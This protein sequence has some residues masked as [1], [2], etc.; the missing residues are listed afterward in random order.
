MSFRTEGVTAGDRVGIF[1][2]RSWPL[3]AGILGIHRA[4]AAY[5]PLDP[6][7]PE[8]RNRGVLE[9][10]DVAA[11]LT[12]SDL[13]GRLPAG[14]WVAIDVE[15]VDGVG[16]EPG[17]DPDLAPESPAYILYTSGSTGRPKGVVVNHANLR[18][19][20]EARLLVYET[21]PRRFLLVPSVAFDSSVAGIFWTLA[22]GGTLVIPTDEQVRDP[23]RLA[24]LVAH[25]GVTGLLCVPSL[26]AQMMGVGAKDLQSLETAI[27]AGESCPSRLV[28]EHFRVLPH[29]R[30]FNEYGPTEATVWA[31][32]HEV[33]ADDAARPVAIGRP[34]PG[35]RVDVVDARGRPVPA[36]IPGHAWIQGPTVAE[37]YWRRADLTADRF[38][39]GAGTGEHRYRTGDR[40]ARAADGR[41]MF[42]GRED[43]QI[44]LR[45]Y[46]IEPGEV[47]ASILELPGVEEAAVVARSPGTG[48]AT[49][50]DHGARQLVAFLRTSHAG[51]PGGLAARS[52][53]AA[54]GPHDTEPPGG[55]LRAAASAERQ[56]RSAA[57]P[58]H[59][60]RSRG[61]SQAGRAGAEPPGNRR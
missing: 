37:G 60:A 13:R 58:G 14:R 47:E 2:G 7:Y 41:L 55:A 23:R 27:V 38:Q 52:R 4:G 61:R 3:V 8:A 12:T 40:M 11:V 35:V 21:P 59:G 46:R 43:E 1:L 30:L 16:P 48:A 42:L 44:K 29:V 15:S 19:S 18:A 28:E 53:H 36:G 10:A 39:A 51:H 26:Y 22:V 24:D 57:T 49:T 31:T 34:I 17:T 9:D 56:D 6:D 45:G 54:A 25:E 33:T 20:T 50:S 5:V 32:V